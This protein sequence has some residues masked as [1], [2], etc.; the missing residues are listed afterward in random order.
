MIIYCDLCIGLIQDMQNFGRYGDHL[1]EWGPNKIKYW[2][3]IYSKIHFKYFDVTL[4]YFIVCILCH[5]ITLLTQ[6]PKISHT[7]SFYAWFLMAFEFYTYNLSYSYDKHTTYDLWGLQIFRLKQWKELKSK[8]IY[9]NM[10]MSPSRRHL[11]Q[12]KYVRNRHISGVWRKKMISQQRRKKNSEHREKYE[13]LEEIQQAAY[14][15]KD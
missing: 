1:A 3:K 11:R 6:L 9:P 2:L 4:T 15:R 13:S 10:G 12:E 7:F 14:N 5:N 8:T